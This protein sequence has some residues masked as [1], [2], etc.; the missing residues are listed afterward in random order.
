MAWENLAETRVNADNTQVDGIFQHFSLYGPAYI[1]N[2]KVEKSP[3]E[4]I[5][6]IPCSD[7]PP[8]QSVI[9]DQPPCPLDSKTG[10]SC[11]DCK[12][13]VGRD[14]DGNDKCCGSECCGSRHD[15]GPLPDDPAWFGC[16]ICCT[17]RA[18]SPRWC[19]SCTAKWQRMLQFEHSAAAVLA[20][21]PTRTLIQDL[22]S[23]EYRTRQLVGQ[24]LEYRLDRVLVSVLLQS[25]Q[26]MQELVKEIRIPGRFRCECTDALGTNAVLKDGLLNLCIRARDKHQDT[27]PVHQA[28]DSPARSF[29]RDVPAPFHLRCLA[30]APHALGTY[31]SYYAQLDGIITAIDLSG[32]TRLEQIAVH[33]LTAIKS[34][35]ALTARYSICLLYGYKSTN[36][37]TGGAS[38][39]AAARASTARRKRSRN[40]GG[41]LRWPTSNMLLRITV[42]LATCP[43]ISQRLARAAATVECKYLMHLCSQTHTCRTSAVGTRPPATPPAPAHSVYLT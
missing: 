33:D 5:E 10:W 27:L 12:V 41:Q 14:K 28:R 29:R 39:V 42:G 21:N 16:C 32:N 17:D 23:A 43:C 31:T 18:L 11:C 13:K 9:P 3:E 6:P 19:K 4:M 35:T 1:K 20:T 7:P 24:A 34:L 37:D 15:H 38:I 40:W 30:A 22:I 2:D 25:S 8:S 26:G 36:T